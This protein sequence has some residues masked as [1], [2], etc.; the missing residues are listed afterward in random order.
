MVRDGKSFLEFFFVGGGWQRMLL[1]ADFE[2]DVADGLVVGRWTLVGS[3][4]S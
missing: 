3:G 1:A 2:A 4:C